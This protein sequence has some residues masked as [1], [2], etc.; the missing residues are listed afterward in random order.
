MQG[1]HAQ[2]NIKVKCGERSKCSLEAWKD[3]TQSRIYNLVVMRICGESQP[4]E[5]G[6]QACIWNQTPLYIHTMLVS[7]ELQNRYDDSIWMNKGWDGR[8]AVGQ[9]LVGIQEQSC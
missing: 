9:E 5:R 6:Q 3:E 4:R 8:D 2:L 7:T 1:K